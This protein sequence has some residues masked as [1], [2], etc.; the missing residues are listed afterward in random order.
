MKLRQ[1]L[2]DHTSE[3]LNNLRADRHNPCSLDRGI[4]KWTERILCFNASKTSRYGNML[5]IL[6]PERQIQIRWHSRVNARAT[7][8]PQRSHPLRTMRMAKRYLKVWETMS[9]LIVFPY[10]LT[11]VRTWHCVMVKVMRSRDVFLAKK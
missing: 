11:T 8:A 3:F 5:Q 10:F 7:A 1:L 2:T 9:M 4:V 6:I